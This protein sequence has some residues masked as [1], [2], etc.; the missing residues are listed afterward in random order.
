M[1]ITFAENVT[2]DGGNVLYSK[3]YTVDVAQGWGMPLVRKGTAVLGKVDFPEPEPAPTPVEV[4]ADAPEFR[5]R[6]G[7]VF[8]RSK[9]RAHSDTEG[10]DEASEELDSEDIAD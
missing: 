1:L 2:D 8:S 9:L 6:N 5:E 3:G 7:G 10:R 4:Q